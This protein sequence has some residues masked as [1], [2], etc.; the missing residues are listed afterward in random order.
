[1]VAVDPIGGHALVSPKKL[2]VPTSPLG[3]APARFVAFDQF[4]VPAGAAP[5]QV[6]SAA[7]EPAASAQ[8]HTTSATATPRAPRRVAAAIHRAIVRTTVA[9]G[10]T[11]FQW[12][13]MVSA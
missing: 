4:G 3:A 10:V 2:S 9:S 12:G 11:P 7:A 5:L 13:P 1:M 8:K 6:K